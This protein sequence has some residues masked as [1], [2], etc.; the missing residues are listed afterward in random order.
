M[1]KERSYSAINL[2][3]QISEDVQLRFGYHRGL[4]RPN[5]EEFTPV[6]IIDD[7][8][9]A[10]GDIDITI[11]SPDLEP[12]TADAFDVSLEWYNR[13]GS[14]VALAVFYKEISAFIDEVNFLCPADGAGLGFGPL[15][16]NGT[17]PATDCVTATN[18]PIQINNPRNSDESLDI[19]GAEISIQQNLD[20]LPSPWSNFGGQFN[21]TY[22]DVDSADT[23]VILPGVSQ[24]T[25]N[26]IAYY[27]DERF[28]VRLAFN[29]RS[30]YFLQGTGTFSGG[31]R[32]VDAR[33]QLDLQTEFKVND[34]ISVIFKA[35]NL[36][37]E[38]LIERE[39]SPE[40][41]RRMD[42]DGRTYA[43]LVNVRL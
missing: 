28:G 5:V 27:E 38:E 33:S 41:V 29:R 16:L 32:V 21:Y 11:G 36:G 20:F 43:L 37:E 39:F 9:V 12:F 31:D 2:S 15:T 26:A 24:D 19:L 1:K 30:E 7:D 10:G 18:D 42:Y 8:S 40:L 4:V 23:E 35:F 22:I 25:F 13:P 6:T 3:M 14:V 34:K 17:D